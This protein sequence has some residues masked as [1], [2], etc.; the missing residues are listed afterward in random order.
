MWTMELLIDFNF[1]I[2][3]VQF[4]WAILV[5]VEMRQ[6]CWNVHQ[7]TITHTITVGIAVHMML[8]SFVK[9]NATLLAVWG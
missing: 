6:T 2:A 3:L 7:T 9:V 5:V 1:L 8:R 4:W